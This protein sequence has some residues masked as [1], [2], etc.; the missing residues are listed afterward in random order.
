MTIAEPRLSFSLRPCRASHNETAKVHDENPRR[1]FS[2]G[3]SERESSR[4]ESRFET[5]SSHDR[6]LE[7][8]SSALSSS[9]R[10]SN[11]AS[12]LRNERKMKRSSAAVLPSTHFVI[13]ARVK[14]KTRGK[15]HGVRFRGTSHKQDSDRVSVPRNFPSRCGNA[16]VPSARR[17]TRRLSVNFPL[18][19]A[20]AT[21]CAFHAGSVFTVRCP[22]GE[23]DRRLLA[24]RDF[25][26]SFAGE[27]PLSEM[28]HLLARRYR[29][30][31]KSQLCCCGEAGDDYRLI[32]DDQV[33]AFARSYRRLGLH[34]IRGPS[35][36]FDLASAQCESQI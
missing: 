21:G 19:L 7:R 23:R 34:F 26:S 27:R 15:S 36:A 17:N 8:E 11:R 25:R 20:L 18:P 14:R 1:I 12:A 29:K 22:N 30:I 9:C 13:Q 33:A 6:S 16:R 24:F 10:S 32:Y 5:A 28:L 35:L 4:A 3:T 31:G 2:P